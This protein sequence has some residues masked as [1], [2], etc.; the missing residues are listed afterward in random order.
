[1]CNS[2]YRISLTIHH[3]HY[4]YCMSNI[5]RQSII[6]SLVIYIGFA[7]G[8][9]NT[10]FFTKQ[11]LFTEEEY[12]LTGI[13]IAIAIMMMALASLGMPSYIF[14]FYHYYNDNL[15]PKK[16]DMITWSLLV[17][18][19]GFILVMI[20]GIAFKHLVIRKF[21]GNSQLLDHLLLL[22]ISHGIWSYHLYSTGSLCLESWT[23]QF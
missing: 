23:N 1:M 12:G 18:T 22:D 8:L 20:A 3:S 21:G 11:G 10:Y 6:S 7:I 9:L 19:I 14:K 17:S 4:L 15:P 13:F 5:R 16:N 2:R